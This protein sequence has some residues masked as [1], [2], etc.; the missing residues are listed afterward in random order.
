MYARDV[1]E[2]A[3]TLQAMIEVSNPSQKKVLNGLLRGQKK[4]DYMVDSYDEEYLDEI[5]KL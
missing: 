1:G 4:L 5:P 2:A 3:E